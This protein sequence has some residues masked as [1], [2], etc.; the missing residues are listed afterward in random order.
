M[1]IGQILVI[2]WRRGWIAAL[3]L[4][5]ALGV[6]AAILVLVPNRYDAVATASMDPG[7]ID[8]LKSDNTVNLTYV[9]GNMLQLV[10]SQRVA[11]DVVRRL[12]LTANPAAQAQ[13][14]KSDSFGRESI[15]DWYA[16]GLAKSVV[17]S[18][19]FGAN[20]LSIKYK[21]GDPNQAALIANAFLA[22]TIDATI[23]MKAASAEQTASWFA[24][25]LDDLRKD[26]QK[27]RA[28]LEDYQA[29]SNVVEP[30]PGG[31]TATSALMAVTGQLSA[32]KSNLAFL[33]SRLA[34]GSTDLALD[35]SD[36]DVK[37]LDLLK[38]R[39]SALEA[40]VM[41]TKNALGP[42][43][44]KVVEGQ[45]NI[46][47]IRKQIPDA[48]QKAA[49]KMRA[50][51]Q[52]Q[53]AETQG[54]IT[55]LEAAQTEAQRSLI[56]AQ[57][58]RNRLGE[59][60]REVGFR[61]EQLNARERMTAAAQ[62]RSKLTFADITVLDKAVP[63]IIPAFPKPMQVILVAIGAGLS[64]GLILAL[65]AEM[66]DRRI[67]FPSDLEFAMPDAPMLGV[68][69]SS[70]RSTLRLRNADRRL[71]TGSVGRGGPL[72]KAPTL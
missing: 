11:L 70:G 3:T 68:I 47:A 28:A 72:E 24:P 32:A 43:N 50:H 25:Q 63:P 67:R 49:E 1:S 64:L 35:P 10:T 27:A 33:Q 37:E 62:L 60:E 57:A 65:I 2:L 26:F 15:E 8:P 22:S 14:R 29:K 16:A 34:S 18:F 13:Y 45:A 39:L 71:L 55:S 58:Q 30:T 40:S 46:A 66:A 42:N 36:A 23:A 44:P 6:A 17:P 5:L 9:Q 56:G 4:L 51:L 41:T 12:N 61:L 20:V 31:D 52:E 53:I 19:G 59:L 38:E 7:G 48:T 54:L 69:P 21:S